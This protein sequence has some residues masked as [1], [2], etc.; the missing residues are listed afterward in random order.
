[1]SV[2]DARFATEGQ[3]QSFLVRVDAALGLPRAAPGEIGNAARA[4]IQ[5]GR[6]GPPPSQGITAT[7]DI[8]VLLTDGQWSVVISPEIQALID[9]GTIPGPIP[10]ITTRTQADIV[11]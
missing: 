9:D 2:A 1:M 3:A 6:Q 11:Q 5:S 8:P 4:W 10:P 7:W